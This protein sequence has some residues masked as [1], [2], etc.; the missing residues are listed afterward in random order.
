MEFW[1]LWG[2]TNQTIRLLKL[3]PDP[4]ATARRIAPR[5]RL[6]QST[7]WVMGGACRKEKLQPSLRGLPNF[8]SEQK[9]IYTT[10]HSD[11]QTQDSCWR[12]LVGTPQI[13][14]TKIELI[15]LILA[16]MPSLESFWILFSRFHLHS[17]Y[18][19][20]YISMLSKAPHET[21]PSEWP[22]P[23]IPSFGNLHAYRNH[24]ATGQHAHLPMTI[25]A[26]S[27][28]KTRP[29]LHMTA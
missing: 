21:V 22:G 23:P 20:L 29:W 9:V 25:C 5:A 11:S 10:S 14:Q 15:A 16:S 26:K 12:L 7:S 8:L 28:W 18:T 24:L 27:G 17:V 6:R 1:D 19:S 2:Y 3:F 4:A 13:I